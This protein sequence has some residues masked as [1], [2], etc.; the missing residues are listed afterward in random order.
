M[1]QKLAVA[2]VHGIGSQKADFADNLIQR[3]TKAFTSKIG[4]HTED[5]A[6]QLVFKPVYWASIFENEE[7]ELWERLTKGGDMDYRRLRLFVINYLAD[8]IAYQPTIERHHNY[9][10]VN[11]VFARSLGFLSETAGEKAPLCVV[12][13]SL[14]SVI[15]SNYFY[16][17][18]FRPEKI[19]ASVRAKISNTPIEQGET[20]AQF[21][22][23]G[24]PIALWG[25]RYEDFGNPVQV[26]A[27]K[28]SSHYPRL[29]GGWWN[30]YDKDDVLAYPLKTLNEQYRK[31]VTAD[32][33]VNV[34]GLFTSWNPFSHDHYATDFD[35]IDRIAGQL[36]E[37]WLN[38]N[39]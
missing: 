37:L 16:D 33:Q 29:Q 35:V 19:H 24:S 13:H 11:E 2:I 31:V 9:D 6:S 21:F 15:T 17:L 4:K 27:P 14:G 8:A 12:A 36:S 26:P 39:R 7:N 28:F 25:L 1:P 20:F 10:N 30:F 34:G 22:T 23:L 18:Q 32:M 5:P 38:L 3:L